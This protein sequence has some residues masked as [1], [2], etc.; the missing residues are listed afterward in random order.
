LHSTGPCPNAFITKLS[1]SGSLVWTTY[2]GGS[3]PD[4]AHAIAVDGTGNVWVAGETVSPDFPT[5]SG[6]ISRTL[7]GETD[8]GPLRYGDAFAAK[9]DASGSHLLYS[10]YLGGSGP[11]GASGIAIDGSGAVYIAGGTQSADF[12]TTAGR[13]RRPTAA[14][15]QISRQASSATD[16]SPSSIPP[17]ILLTRHLPASRTA[18]RR[19]LQWTPQ[20]RHT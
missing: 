7:H 15:S 8:L 13:S 20:G 16:L 2:L 9:L 10:T 12:P 5:T 4:D 11:D 3:G 17:G 14:A 6:A 18:T 19:R 1:A